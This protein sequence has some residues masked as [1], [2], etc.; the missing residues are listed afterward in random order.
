MIFATAVAALMVSVLGLRDLALGVPGGGVAVQ[1]AFW[2]WAAVLIAN[3][4]EALAEGRG[5]ARADSLRATK[6]DTMV[7]CC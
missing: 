1:I 7:R 6:S 4:A 2:L 3:F 5:R